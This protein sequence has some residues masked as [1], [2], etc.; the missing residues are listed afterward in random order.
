MLSSQS[1]QYAAFIANAISEDG[2]DLLITKRDLAADG[3]PTK[4]TPDS[5]T[6]SA[7]VGHELTGV[8]SFIRDGENR[9]K[10]RHKGLISTMYVAKAYRGSGIAKQLLTAIIQRVKTNPD[11]EQINL[12]VLNSNKKA[13]RLYE[14]FGFQTYGTE[15]NSIKWNG[16]YFAEDLM[17][18]HLSTQNL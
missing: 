3:F 14:S 13:K 11:I 6:L 4:D 5:F 1:D 16:A 7:W 10:L 17:A 15:A 18:L 9:E 2:G 8:A 12:I